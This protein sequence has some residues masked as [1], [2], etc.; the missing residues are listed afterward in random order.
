MT[1]TFIIAEAGANHDQKLQQALKLIDVAVQ[2]GADACKFQTYTAEKLFST[3]SKLVNGYDVLTMFKKIEIPREFQSVLKEYCDENKIEFMSTPFDEEA[4]DE[5]FKLGVRRFK[6]SGFESTDLRFIKYVAST[7]LPIIISAGIGT[8][9]N[10]VGEIINTCES[11]GC[12]DITILHCNNGYPTQPE[13]T[14]LKTI[15]TIKQTYSVKV[16]FSDHTIDTITPAIAVSL[17]ASVIE[18]HFTLSRHLTGPDHSFALEPNSLK[19]MV[20]N[21]RHVEK[22][23]GEKSKMTDSELS[24]IQGQRSLVARRKI[25]PNEILTEE[26]VTTKR[27]FYDG[28]IHAKDYYNIVNCGFRSLYQIEKDDFITWKNILT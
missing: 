1:K 11:V 10:F 18:K 27:P 26:N 9:I 7:Q 23:I 3:K 17:G 2:S 15:N 25:E 20:N 6:I 13:E 4:V 14:N 5:L 21:I 28:N 19:E 16:G 22:C 8:S 24:N 12:K